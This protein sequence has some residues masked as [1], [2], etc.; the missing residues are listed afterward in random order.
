[1]DARREWAI[2]KSL[3]DAEVNEE[4]WLLGRPTLADYLHYVKKTVV[5]GDSVPPS[6][7]VDEWRTANDRYYELEE[8]EPGFADQRRI[9]RL[10][11]RLQP[12]V[13]EITSTERFRRAFDTLPTRFAMVEIERIVVSQSHIDLSHVERLKATLP[14]A[15]S[16]EELFR[17]CFPPESRVPEVK[18][19]KAGS[20]K[21]M[22]WSKSNDFQFLD[23]IKVDPSKLG[24]SSFG[25]VGGAIGLVVGYGSNFLSAIESDNRLLLHNGHHRAYAL[26]D[27]GVKYAPVILQKVTRR[28]ELNVVAGAS[29]ANSP[30]FYFKGKRPPVLKDFFD[31]KLRKVHR[32]PRL[33]RVVEVTF[34]IRD[35]ETPDFAA[36]E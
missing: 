10:S 32:T 17:F 4:A 20:R 33:T 34:E 2:E 25:P 27:L 26:R 22:F 18:C 36:A 31:P 14:A 23:A 9:K 21:Y 30:G 13:D 15:P 35:F 24:Y 1:V 7:L 8:T 12:L 28:D 11:K 29:V 3:G 5:G 6:E 19:R 16:E